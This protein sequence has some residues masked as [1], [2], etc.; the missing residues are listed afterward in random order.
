MMRESGHVGV[1]Q[2]LQ[3]L[4]LPER[5]GDGVVRAGWFA[6]IKG[7]LESWCVGPRCRQPLGESTRHVGCRLSW[8]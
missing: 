4:E 6:V 5:R 2:R 1:G 7:V 8:L 3:E